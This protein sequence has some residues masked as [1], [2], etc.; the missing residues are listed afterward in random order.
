MTVT[1]S[2]MVVN[3]IHTVVNRL[4]RFEPVLTYSTRVACR[5][6]PNKDMQL[7]TFRGETGLTLTFWPFDLAMFMENSMTSFERSR[8]RR[9]P[10]PSRN[11][12][13]RKVL[14]IM[15]R[16]NMRLIAY[17][18]CYVLPAGCTKFRPLDFS[19]LAGWKGVTSFVRSRKRRCLF[20]WPWPFDL[21]TSRC[22]CRLVV[23]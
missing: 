21:L 11:D 16:C 2:H 1:N 17:M 14:D 15:Q 8:K 18:H 23:K 4:N 22:S 6:I 12:I 20:C 5:T 10:W 7:D 9:W 19:L 3:L 13:R